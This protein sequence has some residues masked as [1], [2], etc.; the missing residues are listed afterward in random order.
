MLLGDSAFEVNVHFA[1]GKLKLLYDCYFYGFIVD[2]KGGI[3]TVSE[4]ER[5][6]DA[7]LKRITE[8]NYEEKITAFQ[9]LKEST[10]QLY[11]NSVE[12]LDEADNG[13]LPSWQ[14]F[15]EAPFVT[16]KEILAL[17]SVMPTMLP[18]QIEQEADD[19]LQVLLDKIDKE[20]A[21][22]KRY[23][24]VPIISTFERLTINFQ[25]HV[26]QCSRIENKPE[27]KQE[28]QR[29]IN[30]LDN[31]KKVLKK[32]GNL[33][34][35]RDSVTQLCEKFPREAKFE[36]NG[37]RTWF[38]KYII[39]PFEQFKYDVG[40][41]FE[42]ILNKIS[43]HHKDSPRFFKKPVDNVFET[44]QEELEK[45]ADYKPPKPTK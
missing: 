30:D 8:K 38:Q 39:R 5:Y 16:L 35:F 29:F 22:A 15:L 43:E 26:A 9:S 11:K 40:V 21:N 19:R 10:Q 28:V 6:V 7:E 17:I 37:T 31:A 45:L 13:M 44:Y 2:K 1:L 3:K 41:L 12:F 18:D 25:Q 42:S 20:E 33:D 27:M 4:L 36:I 24:L 23:K 34:T 14:M 32:T